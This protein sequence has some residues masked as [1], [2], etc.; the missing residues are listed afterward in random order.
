MNPTPGDKALSLSDHEDHSIEV[1]TE[2]DAPSRD[3]T[4]GHVNRKRKEDSLTDEDEG[5]PA[6]SS[7]CKKRKKHSVDEPDMFDSDFKGSLSFSKKSS[8]KPVSS[9]RSA[10]TSSG[11]TSKWPDDDSGLGSSFSEP[12][13]PKDKKSRKTKSTGDA[14]PLEEE[15][16]LWKERQEKTNRDNRAT[17]SLLVK[18][19]P[20][21]YGLEA[22]T[23]KNYRSQHVAPGRAN[24]K[25]M[26]DHSG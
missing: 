20:I 14:D 4:S 1:L 13:K 25:N 22:E 23:M 10:G 9:G 24:S 5:H 18:Y 11:K 17:L 16:R 7:R 19:Q 2:R 8:A 3:E 26:D 21:Q 6:G 12:K 15:L